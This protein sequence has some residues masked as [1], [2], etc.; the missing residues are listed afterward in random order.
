MLPQR[1]VV[2]LIPLSHLVFIPRAAVGDSWPVWTELE[3]IVVLAS[4]DTSAVQ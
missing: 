2:V 3:D 4:R 1:V